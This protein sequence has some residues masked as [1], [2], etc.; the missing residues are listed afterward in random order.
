M[1]ATMSPNPIVIAKAHTLE[2]F[3]SGFKKGGEA[4]SSSAVVK[5]QASYFSFY[6]YGGSL[7]KVYAGCLGLLASRWGQ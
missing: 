3:L 2:Q 1:D 5:G 6:A 4:L 7:N